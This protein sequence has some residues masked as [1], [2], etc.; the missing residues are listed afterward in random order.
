MKRYFVP[1]ILVISA[2]FAAAQGP[3]ASTIVQEYTYAPVGVAQG[4]TVRVNVANIG[5]GTAVCTGNL[6]FINSDGTSIKNEDFTAGAGQTAS[7]ALLASDISGS[8]AT[9][10]VRG[11]VK[12]NRQVGPPT[13]GAAATACTA[14]MSLEVIDIATG[15]TRA[16]LT[17]PTAVSGA[18][19]VPVTLPQ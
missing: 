2:G 14:V 8:P 12:I 18:F 10:V 16:I 5:S 15:Q 1:L 9:A 6:S 13:A 11:F 4:T 17:N 19:V 3:P 7:Y